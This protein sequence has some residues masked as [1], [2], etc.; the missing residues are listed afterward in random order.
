ML[1]T[2]WMRIEPSRSAIVS[3]SLYVFPAH[4]VG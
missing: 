2:G 1:P 4:A 3:I